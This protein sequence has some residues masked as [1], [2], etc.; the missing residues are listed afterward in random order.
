MDGAYKERA[1]EFLESHWQADALASLAQF[2]RSPPVCAHGCGHRRP[3]D[4]CMLHDLQTLLHLSMA[5]LARLCISGASQ[6]SASLA[7]PGRGHGQRHACLQEG[8]DALAQRLQPQVHHTGL[9]LETMQAVGT[10]LT[11]VPEHM[12]L[13]AEV[14][15][16]LR[17]RRQMV[18]AVDSRVDFALAELLAFGTLS[19]RRPPGA[20][21]TRVTPVQCGRQA[22]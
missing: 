15:A 2:V 5:L 22:A 20:M 7:H 3:I 11:V 10:Q 1:T 17:R 18:A 21:P 4:D 13:H 14:E 16:L 6:P 9:P 12:A 8:P 19:L